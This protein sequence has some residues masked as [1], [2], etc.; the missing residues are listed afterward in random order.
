MLIAERIAEGVE[1]PEEVRVR[2]F[3]SLGLV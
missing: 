2:T 3:K 1:P